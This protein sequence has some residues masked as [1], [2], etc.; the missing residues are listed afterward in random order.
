MAVTIKKPEEIIKLREGG[1]RLARTLAAVATTARPGISAEE[2]D[3]AARCLIEEGGDRP[4]FLGYR[5]KRDAKPFPAT[6]CVS[7]NDEV[8]HGVPTAEKVLR[9]GDIVG[10]DAGLIH[11]GLFVDA[12]M[13]I[14]VGGKTDRAG[15]RLLSVTRE[16][17]VVGI[18]AA[19]AG[20][21][22]GDIGAAIEAFVRP[23][24][25]GIVR[26]LAGHGVGY[27]VHEDPF[28]PNFGKRGE[29]VPLQSG[30]VIA[31]EPMLT[32]GKHVIVLADDGFTYKTK[33]G[34]RATHFEHTILITDG[35]PEILT[36]ND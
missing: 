5:G 33:D 15:E 25:F 21:T 23:S 1:R 24:G 12:A 4:S 27:A 34:S 32:E 16:A 31:I 30:M 3:R 29:G 19:R 10:I 14:A 9:A 7:V 11:E 13:T 2:L 28:I 18:A 6:L 20:A 36:R 26:E 8:V 17:L 22:T 35:E